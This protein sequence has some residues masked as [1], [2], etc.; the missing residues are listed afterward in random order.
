[1]NHYRFNKLTKELIDVKPHIIV[2]GKK[3]A[4]FSIY[5]S[6]M[7]QRYVSFEVGAKLRDGLKCYVYNDYRE[8]SDYVFSKVNTI[9]T[10]KNIKFMYPSTWDK[11]KKGRILYSVHNW[12]DTD[13][14]TWL[15]MLI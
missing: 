6:N 15:L 11:S 13:L 9:T 10:E 7:L 14:K 1:M 2:C 8:V 12:I 3:M 5:F 4:G